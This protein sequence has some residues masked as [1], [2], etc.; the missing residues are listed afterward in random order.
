MSDR[1]FLHDPPFNGLINKL[2]YGV[3]EE[4]GKIARVIGDLSA[5]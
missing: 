3:S 1:V 2:L 5:L 4:A